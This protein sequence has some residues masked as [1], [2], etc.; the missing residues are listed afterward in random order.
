MSQNSKFKLKYDELRA[1][2][3][4]HQGD[5]KTDIASNIAMQQR[6]TANVRN[7]CFVW[8]NGRQK[9][10]A[11]GYLIS[12]ELNLGNEV[13]IITLSFTSDVVTL[14]GYHLQQLFMQ[15][16]NHA[17]SLISQVD[18]RYTTE[19]TENESTV[20]EIIVTPSKG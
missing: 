16:S 8:P 19:T 5:E 11:Y 14:K 9:F 17:T 2:D 3:P 7:I 6:P 15:L 18:P 12:G 20:I 10:F 1:G 13:N 4:T